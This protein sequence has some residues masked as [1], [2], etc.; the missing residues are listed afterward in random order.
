VKASQGSSP[1]KPDAR[2]S[3]TS[4]PAKRDQIEIGDWCSFEVSSSRK[5]KVVVG[6]VL[7]FVY[8]GGKSKESK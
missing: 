8:L 5:K 4:L 2:H 6:R 7:G 1:C 3:I